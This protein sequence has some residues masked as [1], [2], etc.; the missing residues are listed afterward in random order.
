MRPRQFKLRIAAK[1]ALLIGLLGA[2]S[3]LATFLSL[4]RMDRVERSNAALTRHVWPARLALA[5]AKTSM[6]AMGGAL[7]R[8]YAATDDDGVVIASQTMSGEYN[9]ARNSLNNVLTYFPG[10][11][12]D[13][14]LVLSKLEYAYGIAEQV[15]GAIKA[16]NRNQ[17]QGLLELRFDPAL[18]DAAGQMNRLINILGGEASVIAAEVEATRSRTLQVILGIVAL[19]IVVTLGLALALAHRSLGGPLRRLAHSMDDLAR[20]ELDI[21]IEGVSR[22][23]EV[24]TMAR[25]M[26]VFRDNARLLRDLER[27]RRDDIAASASERGAMLAKIA[28]GFEKQ[29]LGVAE[30]LAGSSTALQRS[31]ASLDAIADQS[32]EKSQ[33]AVHAAKEIEQVSG[34][35]AEAIEE[36]SR[37]M[38]AIKTHI[39]EATT[40]VAEAGKRAH[41][42]ARN[43][44]HLADTVKDIDEVAKMITAI[45]SQ[46]NL[47]A[48]NAT[49]EA[50]RAGDAGRG[51]AVVA[52]EVKSLAVQTA[53][54]LGEIRSKTGSIEGIIDG[55]QGAT[56]AMVQ[57]M[58]QVE[59][60]SDAVA[61]V[62]EQQST[63]TS[64]ISATVDA[65]SR[66][67]REMAGSIEA[68]G[69]FAL[70]TRE[71]AR[72]ILQ[73][74]ADLNREVVQLRGNAVDFS[75]RIKSA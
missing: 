31:A 19:G 46:T 41:L 45:A 29:I 17:A 55:V 47:L 51:F 25:S 34:T 5:E 13:L 49:I 67:T 3:A 70:E 58:A 56:Q 8:A 62:V 32:G 1:A 57:V 20:G 53:T 9:A 42:A 30:V 60:L 26:Q 21:A 75:S 11:K 50:A 7:Y 2:M 43:A 10:R 74:V 22:S 63:A 54:A 35:V 38:A 69:T 59:G 52:Q 44:E 24:G 68:V 4:D 71:G 48:L 33:I 6:G 61:Q 64:R 12:T 27:Q 39:G 66:G 23:D 16:R 36:L 15:R 72:Q 73:A 40:T 28:D 37:S 65:A 14:D 18:D